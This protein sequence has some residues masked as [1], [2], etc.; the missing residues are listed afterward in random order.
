[1]AT[2]YWEPKAIAVAQVDTGSIDT[3]DAASTYTVT[4]GGVA[5]SEAGDT[6]VATT[7]T[8]LRASLNAATHPYFAAITW[9]GA[10]GDI[11][12]TA[13]VAGAPFIAALTVA[14]GTGTVT[15][16]AAT[17]ANASKHDV[18]DATN[19]SGETLPTTG[20]DIVIGEGNVSLL[21][22]LEAITV[23]DTLTIMQ[24]FTGNVG[25]ERSG[26][27]TSEDGETRETDLPEYRTDYFRCDLD[28]IVHGRD[29]GLGV[30][31]LGSQRTKI[32]NDK[33]GAS[34]LRVE[35]TADATAGAKP[36]LRY[37]ADNAGADIEI[38][39]APGGLA[40]AA[41]VPGET[42]TV[43]DVTILD[44]TSGSKVVTGPGVTLSN[45]KQQGGINTLDAGADIVTGVECLGGTLTIIGR[46][47]TIPT[48]DVT[49]G[50]VD[51]Q[52]VDTTGVEWTTV[53]VS[54]GGRLVLTNVEEGR[55]ATNFNIQE[56]GTVE[57]DWDTLTIT[58]FNKPT[59]LVS[60]VVSEV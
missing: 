38:V 33:A 43:G 1:M 5:I 25:L 16:F 57:A 31:G 52:H 24:S 50:E 48:L 14:G 36:A 7:A 34:L 47:Y 54:E 53:N 20:D 13:D 56:G 4:I 8:N 18:G 40:I 22:R 58:N 27:A 6:D 49:G 37:K 44:S 28:E 29:D 12:G 10:T 17:T 59:G 23:A 42:S 35:N 39:S 60:I 51:D 11:I 45:W 15:D 9:S 30:T 32:H 55:T 2:R 41:D 26:F 21:Y 19:W 46:D 3:F